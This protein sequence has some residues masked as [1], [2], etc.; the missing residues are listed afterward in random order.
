M[1]LHPE[2][3][4]PPPNHRDPTLRPY[5]EDWRL[6]ADLCTR[7]GNWLSK[8]PHPEVTEIDPTTPLVVRLHLEKEKQ[9]KTENNI[10]S[11]DVS[12]G[13]DI[14]DDAVET[15]ELPQDIKFTYLFEET[16]FAGFKPMLDLTPKVFEAFVLFFVIACTHYNCFLL[17][18]I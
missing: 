18:K 11:D 8:V 15:T 14:D 2:H 3:W 7:A 17:W 5:L 4:T 1:I 12:A 16:V 10:T 6:V 9:N 13:C